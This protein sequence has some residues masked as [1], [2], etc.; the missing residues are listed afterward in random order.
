MFT[1]KIRF[2]EHLINPDSL[3]NRMEGGFATGFRFRTRLGY[4]RSLALSCIKALALTVDGEPVPE[5]ALSF[6]INGKRF[7]P[8]QLPDLYAEYWY[9]LDEAEIQVDRLGGISE[10]DHTL[11]LTLEL[12]SPYMLTGPNRAYATIDSSD[13][14]V[15]TR[16]GA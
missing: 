3:E 15:L 9:L 12:R 7:L 14:C 11:A 5:A 13:A 1:L 8:A 4:Y 2:A 16:R 10:G 6:R